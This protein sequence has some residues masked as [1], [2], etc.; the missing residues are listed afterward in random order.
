[1]DVELTDQY[2]QFLKNYNQNAACDSQCQEQ[3][4]AQQLKQN[5][6]NALNNLET[7]PQQV[8]TA[9]QEYITFTEGTSSYSQYQQSSLE[10]QAENISN[11]YQEKFNDEMQN[12][13]ILLSTYSGLYTNYKNVYDLNEIYKKE[14]DELQK[15]IDTTTTDTLTNDRKTFY[16]NQATES[17][18]KYYIF[19]CIIYGIVLLYYIKNMIT[20]KYYTHFA[21]GGLIFLIIYPFIS[22]W[23]SL[24]IISFY[25][26]II[27][28][29]PKNQYQDL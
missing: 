21:V 16:E 12:V 7:A 22:L 28:L 26:F 5:Y 25:N 27:S 29:L 14:N 13:N 11:E 4:E 6:L 10:Q 2:N 19:F 24:K 3:K 20:H 1:M 15:D 17:L 9:Y 23:L 8:N 18:K